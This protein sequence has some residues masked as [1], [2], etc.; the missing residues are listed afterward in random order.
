[1]ARILVRPLVPSA[2]TPNHITT[3]RLVVGI[4]AAGAAAVGSDGWRQGAAGLFLASMLLDRADGELAR[5][6]NRKS[7]FGHK[8]DLVSDAVVN[9]LIFMGLG[10]GLRESTLWTVLMGVVAGI[11][12]AAILWL[13][14][15]A[16]KT[17]GTRAAELGH[18]AGLDPDDSMLIV[19]LSMALGFS[20]PL[21]YAATVGAPLFA[22]F[23]FWRFRYY[24]GSHQ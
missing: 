13:V 8:Y 17:A 10:T 4:T 14:M 5:L 24:L 20:T 18:V 12:V 1:M 15:R 19:P 21:L 7:A 11:A 16:E 23:F 22:I 9:A 3:L 2:V 6:S